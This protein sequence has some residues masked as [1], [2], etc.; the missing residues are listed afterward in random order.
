MVRQKIGK[1]HQL[2]IEQCNRNSDN[3]GEKT[4]FYLAAG[5][6]QTQCSKLYFSPLVGGHDYLAKAESGRNRPQEIGRY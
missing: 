3:I 1:A 2:N 5:K 6:S 4:N